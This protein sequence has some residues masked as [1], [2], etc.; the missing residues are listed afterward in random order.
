MPRFRTSVSIL[1]RR[2]APAKKFEPPTWREKLRSALERSD[3]AI[4]LAADVRALVTEFDAMCVV[5]NEERPPK[6]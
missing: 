5:L 1:K 3:G 2:R 4:L 6:P